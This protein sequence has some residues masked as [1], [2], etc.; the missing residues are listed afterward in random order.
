[1]MPAVFLA[2]RGWWAV[3]AVINQHN[4]SII[5]DLFIILML[6]IQHTGSADFF[7]PCLFSKSRPVCEMGGSTIGIYHPIVIQSTHYS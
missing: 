7:S 5:N 1:M 3:L 6:A 4:N 2:V